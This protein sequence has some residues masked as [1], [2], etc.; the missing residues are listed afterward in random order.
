MPELPEAETIRRQLEAEVLGR[1]IVAARARTARSVRRHR[2]CRDFSACVAG[3]KIT[4]VGRRGKAVVLTLDGSRTLIIRLGMTGTIRVVSAGE[5]L[6]KHTHVILSLDDGR[7]VRFEDVRKFGEAHV[8]MGADWAR[9]PDLARLGPEPL[10]PQFT[11]AHLRGALRR[12]PGKIKL[13]LMDQGLV[14]GLGN[15]YTDEALWRARVHP[16][17]AAN[18]LSAPEV[19]LLHHSIRGVLREAIKRGGTSARDETYR[20]VHG[21]PGYFGM[22]LAVYQRTGQPCPRCGA[23]IARLPL[24]S[25]RAAHFCPKCQPV[26]RPAAKGRAP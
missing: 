16:M 19:A 22:E 2:S 15:I 21:R 11:R 6:T 5:P 4:A 13:V 7:D 12:R 8:A 3:R 20:D 26:R 18:T 23:P 17:R 25:G 9:I 14:A 10:S 24:A 1:T